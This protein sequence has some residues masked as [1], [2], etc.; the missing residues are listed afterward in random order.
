M[1]ARKLNI[2]RGKKFIRNFYITKKKIAFLQ[3]YNR[4]ILLRSFLVVWE[5]FFTEIEKK[6]NGKQKNTGYL[7]LPLPLMQFLFR[8]LA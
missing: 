5:Y 4:Y 1:K 2:L 7:Q 8:L 3:P 6:V